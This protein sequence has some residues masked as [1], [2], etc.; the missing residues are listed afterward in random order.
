MRYLVESGGVDLAVAREI[1]SRRM[2]LFLAKD[3]AGAVFSMSMLY[4]VGAG[5]F[6][7]VFY[8]AGLDPDSSS[9]S[10]ALTV[11]LLS[12]YFAVWLASRPF[13]FY[14]NRLPS[15]MYA[16]SILESI[17]FRSEPGIGQSDPLGSRRSALLAAVR[18][19][20]RRAAALDAVLPKGVTN[21]FAALLRAG[22]KDIRKFC[23]SE[24]SLE[25]ELPSR[26]SLTIDRMVLLLSGAAD[27]SIYR[28]SADLWCAFDEDG[29]PVAARS[30][31]K[32]ARLK[33]VVLNIGR[34]VEPAGRATQ[35]LIQLAL[36]IAIAA[37]VMQ[38][39]VDL[40]E[41]VKRVLQ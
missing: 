17:Y 16:L 18:A 15:D 5:V 6:Y 26:I 40:V 36:L 23:E 9:G 1:A 39:R 27:S 38:G 7:A 20:E 14:L 10:G 29:M 25:R 24:E 4:S 8:E 19:V 34:V 21:S 22:T 33:E 35:T 3:S 31:G 32:F 11:A 12:C 41:V 2:S 28:E 37:L 13:F 30:H